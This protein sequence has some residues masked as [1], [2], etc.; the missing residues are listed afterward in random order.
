MNNTDTPGN[1]IKDMFTIEK[2]AEFSNPCIYQHRVLFKINEATIPKTETKLPGLI[3]T[4]V[5]MAE[6]LSYWL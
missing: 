3:K 4:P 5:V 1:D 6:G 2:A